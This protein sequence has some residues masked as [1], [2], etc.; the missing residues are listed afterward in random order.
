MP[1]V[2][3]VSDFL[4]ETREDLSS[5]TTSN[6]VAHIPQCRETVNKLEEV[7]LLCDVFIIK[8]LPF[9][10]FFMCS[11]IKKEDVLCL[12]KLLQRIVINISKIKIA[13]HLITKVTFT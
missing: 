9:P 10:D 12:K 13:N 5:P 4:R 8:L 6:F 7:S 2:I 11:Y 1:G 3:S